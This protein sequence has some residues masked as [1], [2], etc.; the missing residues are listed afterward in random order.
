MS[1]GSQ[2]AKDSDS[3]RD[4]ERADEKIRREHESQARFAKSAQIKN[5]DDDENPD[6][7]P[8][9]MRLEIRDGGNKRAD[10]RR[11]ADG[12]GENVVGEKRS[13][14]EQ[15]GKYAEVAL[16]DGVRATALRVGLDG[17]AIRKINDDEQDDDRRAERKN[18]VQTE[19]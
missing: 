2:D 13:R 6:A 18:V 12:G 17:L 9:H 10:S 3:N 8:D 16:R 5:C 7:Q 14:R 11:Y 19:E 15:T 4:S 1:A